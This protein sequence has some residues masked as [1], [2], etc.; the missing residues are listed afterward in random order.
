MVKQIV[1]G[2]VGTISKDSEMGLEESEVV[3]KIETIQN[4]VILGSVRL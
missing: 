2:A 1:N 4:A 3:G